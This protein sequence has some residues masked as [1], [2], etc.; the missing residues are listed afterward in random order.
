MLA[1][2]TKYRQF[3][4]WIKGPDCT[5]YT[6]L[7]DKPNSCNIRFLDRFVQLDLW[8][9]LVDVFNQEKALVGAFSLLSDY[10]AW[11]VPSF[12]D[13][14]PDDMCNFKLGGLFIR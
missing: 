12:Q 13:V 9:K 14:N 7:T 6:F 4:E 8:H 10:E 11:D 2:H 5:H 1:T 3:V